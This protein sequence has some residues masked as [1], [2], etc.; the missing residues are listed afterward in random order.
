MNLNCPKN[1][2]ATFRWPSG[3]IVA[4]VL[5]AIPLKIIGYG[6]L[7]GDDALR[8]AAK[9]VSGKPW[10]EILVLGDTLKDGPS[11][12]RLAGDARRGAARDRLER[13]N[14]AS[15]FPSS[16]CSSWSNAALWPWLKRP[17]AWLVA[18]LAAMIVSDLPQRFLLGRP[19]VVHHRGR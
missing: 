14:A 17:E 13:G 16:R 19:F 7:P 1:S 15:F 12:Y 10:S 5:L 8:H 11:E 2:A 18:L 9:A 4:L 6:Y 3:L